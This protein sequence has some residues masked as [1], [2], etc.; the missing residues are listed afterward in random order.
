MLVKLISD[1]HL[2]Y[3]APFNYVDAGEQ[4][5]IL[6]GDIGVG[7]RG[8]EWA[9]KAIPSHIQVLYVPG[10][11]EYYGHDYV[12][13][14]QDYGNYNLKGTNVKI[15][16]EDSIVIEDI[17]FFGTSL[18]VDFKLYSDQVKGGRDWKNGLNDSRYIQN[19]GC[20]IN[21]VDVISWYERSIKYLEKVSTDKTAVLITHHCPDLS[22]APKY[23]NDPYTP[24]FASCIPTDIHSKFQF[25]FHGHTHC[26]MNYQYPYGTKVRC[27][28]RGYGTENYTEFES[29]YL[30][31]I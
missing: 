5:C 25:H 30:I 27:N 10:N 3:N 4:V 8:V 31:E 20:Y 26:S 17:E 1:L 12:F 14:N 7:M 6:A 28:P 23:R 2:G 19:G 21:E 16:M 15:L 9:E 24:G 22:V 13:L 29:Q 18:W 11:H